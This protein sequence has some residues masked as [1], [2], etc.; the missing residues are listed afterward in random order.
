MLTNLTT[1]TNF[2]LLTEKLTNIETIKIAL[3]FKINYQFAISNQDKNYDLAINFGLNNLNEYQNSIFYDIN[4]FQQINHHI[5]EKM[6]FAITTIY[7]KIP[8]IKTDNLENNSLINFLKCLNLTA[9]SNLNISIQKYTKKNKI[10]EYYNYKTHTLFVS[11]TNYQTIINEKAMILQQLNQNSSI[12]EPKFNQ[13]DSKN[14]YFNDTKYLGN[15]SIFQHQYHDVNKNRIKNLLIPIL[16]T[17]L[18]T[19][20]LIPFKNETKVD[21]FNQALKTNYSFKYNQILYLETDL[22]YLKFFLKSTN[23]GFKIR[24]NRLNFKKKSF[25]F[26]KIQYHF[27]LTTKKYRFNQFEY[28]ID[29]NGKTRYSLGIIDL[30]QKNNSKYL[31]INI[32]NNLA[33]NQINTIQTL[34]SKLILKFDLELFNQIW[35][36]ITENL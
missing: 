21:K 32:K 19:L 33:I 29:L 1:I 16:K 4:F 10:F 22:V 25:Y 24:N 7:Q 17:K 13:L 3:K 6:D 27:N 34:Y 9:L 8:M 31:T 2:T 11:K 30:N 14:D 20:K 26:Q 35:K 12:I 18:P 28:L 5:K 23:Q 15:E 36:I